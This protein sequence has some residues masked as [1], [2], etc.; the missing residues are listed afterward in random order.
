MVDLNQL[1]AVK[2]APLLGALTAT[3]F[4]AFYGHP[5]YFLQGIQH[6][7][8]EHTITRAKAQVGADHKQQQP[9][10]LPYPADAFPGGRRVQTVYGTIQVFEWGPEHGEKVLLV[11]GLGTPCI[12]LGN[13]AKEFVRRGYRVMMF[14]LF[15][16]GYSETPND[17]PHDARLYT[18]QILLVLSSSP[19]AWTG[20]SAFHIIGFSLGG[21]IAVAFAAYHATMLRSIT[22]ICPG[23]LIRTSHISRRSQVLYSSS[24]I[25][26]WLRLRLLRR[27]LEPSNGAPSADVPDGTQDADVDFDAVPIAADRPQVRIGDVIRWQLRANPGFVPSYLSTILGSLVYRRFDRIWKVLRDELARR[28]TADAPPGLPGG[29]VSLILAERDVI[30]V[31]D[32]F[33]EDMEGLLCREDVDLHVMKGGHEIGVVRGKDVASI[34]VESWK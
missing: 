11:H 26:E 15:G 30:V 19:L 33:L 22:L 1:L 32:E 5:R 16:R 8:E 31:K 4:F 17:L 29:R 10:E 9:T 20:S 27:D 13:M 6:L 24:F 23:G 14:D 28:R 12:A 21:S 2:P 3:I 34:A 25:P 7:P 18:T